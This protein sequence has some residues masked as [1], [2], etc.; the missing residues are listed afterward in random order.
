MTQVIVIIKFNIYNSNSKI[1][2]ITHQSRDKLSTIKHLY[3][4]NVETKLI[5]YYEGVVT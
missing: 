5:Y 1:L 2:L 3:G 4:H